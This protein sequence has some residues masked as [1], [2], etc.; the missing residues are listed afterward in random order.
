MW[1]KVFDRLPSN[2]S[3]EGQ[4]NNEKLHKV[5]YGEIEE[6]KNVFK[7]IKTYQNIDKAFGKTLDLI[8]GNVLEYRAT[9][10]DELYRQY[11]KTK[12][13]ANLSQGDIETIN[14]V[15]SFLLKEEYQSIS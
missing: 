15:A 14:Q 3:Q 12:I 10:D 9:D 7:D 2:Y 4:I 1:N 8:G 5:I 13:I 6:I 11:I